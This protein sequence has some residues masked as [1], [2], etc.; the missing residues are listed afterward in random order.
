M[1]TAYVKDLAGIVRSA[2]VVSATH[3]CRETLR[4]LFQHPESKCIVVCN[5][6]KEPL[7]LIMSEDFFLKASGRHGV[8][9]FYREPVVNYMNGSPLMADIATPPED[10]RIDMVGRPDAFKNNFVIV[11]QD[12]KFN[13]IAY[14]ADLT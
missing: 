9:M 3:T 8:D 6:E 13:G 10:L 2:P 5:A 4:V 7:G 11:T 12:N 14:A 1:T